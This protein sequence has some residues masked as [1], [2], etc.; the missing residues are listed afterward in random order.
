MIQIIKGEPS[1]LALQLKSILKLKERMQIAAQDFDCEA[2]SQLDRLCMQVM[3]S[4]PKE[5]SAYSPEISQ[6][7]TAIKSLYAQ[8]IDQISTEIE[9][10]QRQVI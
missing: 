2:M 4:L 6:Q 9:N 1:P 3:D 10:Q 7:L 8:F 5:I